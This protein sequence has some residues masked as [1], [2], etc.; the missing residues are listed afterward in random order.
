MEHRV[1]CC[2][3]VRVAAIISALSVLIISALGAA[4]GWYAIYGMSC[5]YHS[6]HLFDR[7][8]MNSG[9][10]CLW[11]YKKFISHES[12]RRGAGHSGFG[13]SLHIML[14]VIVYIDVTMVYLLIV[15]S[16]PVCT[17]HEKTAGRSELPMVLMDNVFSYDICRYF[18]CLACMV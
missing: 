18:I 5:C 6:I 8:K 11:I 13:C 2:V 10:S 4:A 15:V 3:P 14:W 7:N 9:R 12:L 16:Q 17:H 1:L